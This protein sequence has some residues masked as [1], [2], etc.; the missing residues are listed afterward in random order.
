MKIRCMMIRC[1]KLTLLLF[2]L[3]LFLSL[4]ACQDKKKYQ[5]YIEGDLTYLSV[6]VSGQLIQMKVEKGQLVQPGQ[7]LFTLEPKPEL[8]SMQQ[9]LATVDQ[10]KA[11]LQDLQKGKRPSEL[12]AIKAQIA[13][14]QAQLE[15]AEIEL[16]RKQALVKQAGLEQA[17]LDI[18]VKNIAVAKADLEQLKENYITATLGARLDQIVEIK[19]QLKASHAALQSAEWVLAQKTVLAPVSSQ[20][21]D[22]YYYIGEQVP[23]Y[24]PVLSLLD[25]NNIKAIFWIPEADLVT[26]R[27][28]QK[29]I[30]SCDHCALVEATVHFISPQPEYT[31][32]IIYSHEMRDK[33]RYRVEA[34][35]SV[36][37]RR[38][39]HPGQPI[40]VIFGS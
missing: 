24:Q 9:A 39:M 22:R 11:H 1:R 20:V 3:I 8:F 27:L 10:V 23:A 33:L 18:A 16:K 5:G 36:S 32:P 13:A 38:K 6:P 21:F 29:I 15:Y 40:D 4:V 31:P 12:A 14:S 37:D 2:I 26:V 17:Q 19:E 25:P 30:V 28:G 35:F 7:L 34:G